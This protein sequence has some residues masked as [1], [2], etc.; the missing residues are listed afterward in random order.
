MHPQH[1]IHHYFSL[2]FKE[3]TILEAHQYEIFG[4]D[5]DTREE[6]VS[7]SDTGQNTNLSQ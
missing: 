3:V 4:A 2:L 7:I 6:K 5:T 1:L